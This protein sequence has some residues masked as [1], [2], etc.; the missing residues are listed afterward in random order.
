MANRSIFPHLF[1]SEFPDEPILAKLNEAADAPFICEV[2]LPVQPFTRFH[3]RKH[4]SQS[5]FPRRPCFYHNK[6]DVSIGVRN[7]KPAFTITVTF[8][9]ECID[10]S[11]FGC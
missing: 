11:G 8:Y 1:D 5:Q 6:H 10:Y 3:E 7:D 4:M 2:T 9:H